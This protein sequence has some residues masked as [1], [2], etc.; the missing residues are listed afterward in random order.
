MLDDWTRVKA[1]FEQAIA[2]DGAERSAFLA[3]A[4]GSDTTLRQRVDLLLVSHDAG[5]SFLEHTAGAVLAIDRRAD[6]LSGQTLGT[7]RLLSRVGTGAMGEV[8]LAHDEKLNRRV[9]VK[10][11]AQHLAADADRLRR[12]RPEAHAV[13]S[14]NHPHIVVVHDVGEMDGRPFI[15]TEFVEGA[16]LRERLAEGPLPIRGAIEIAL[17]ITSALAAAHARGVVHRDIKPENVMIR[18]DGYVKVLDFGLAK[19]ANPE[20]SGDA[21]PGVVT[22]PGHAAGTPSYMSPEQA[23]AEPVDARTDMFSVGAVL[24]EMVTSRMAFPGDSHAVVLAGILEHTPPSPV[25]SNRGVSPELGRIIMKALEK[26]R[27]LRYQT[28]GDMRADL[29]RVRRDSD[30]TPGAAALTHIRAA[31]RWPLVLLP[32]VALLMAAAVWLRVRDQRPNEALPRPDAFPLTTNTGQEQWPAFSPDGKQVTY[33]W[34]GDTGGNPNI[35][36]KL[37]DAGVPLRLTTTP[38]ADLSP[39]WSPDGRYI[40]FLRAATDGFEILSVPSLG[41]PER[42]LAQS[43]AT[44]FVGTRY[45]PWW[46]TKV[47]WSPN[48]NMLAIVDRSSPQSADSIFLLTIDS[49]EKRRLTVP[50]AESYGDGFP[51][52]SPDGRTLAFT[53][54]A[55]LQV[56][57]IFVQTLGPDMSPS[58]EPK[59]VT[60]DGRL[61]AGLDWTADGRELVFSSN[62]AGRHSLWRVAVSGGQPEPLGAGGEDAYAPS[63][64]RQGGRLAY[65]HEQRDTNIWQLAS[66]KESQPTKFI[67]SKREDNAAQFSPD[68]RKIV[69]QSSRSGSFEIWVADRDGSH[70]IQLTFFGGPQAGS[71]RWSPDSRQIAFDSPTKGNTEIHVVSAEGGSPRRLTTGTSDNVRPSWSTDGRWIYF[72]SKRSGEWQVWKI[73]VEGGSAVQVT[74]NGGREAYESPDG[75]TVYYSK[76]GVPGIWRLAVDGGEETQVL[77]AGMQGHWAVYEQGIYVLSTRV[78]PPVIESFGFRAPGRERVTA[79]AREVIPFDGFATTVIASSLDGRSILYVQADQTQSEIMV[80]EKFR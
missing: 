77:A 36:V 60:F 38:D 78:N 56:R 28:A 63:I 65:S 76:L 70:P 73:P 58:G 80:L 17:Q 69:F 10:L 6:D 53:R 47:A 46:P 79:L 14:L 5:K 64:A 22:Q 66:G 4:C 62:R 51:T 72:G 25:Q 41:G 34:D 39:A 11:I 18:P 16:T 61:I 21:T 20:P 23:R 35:F 26:D 59:R 31:Q 30:V 42:K 75:K 44:N 43:I 74:K 45:G 40:A 37:I 7:Y 27:E 29:L 24:Y 48:G 68:G 2:L 33:S 55:G 67:A 49:G 52:F 12:F 13:S 57:D 3:A 71:P 9:A 8:Y 19:L 1:V 54:G 32:V 15:V 50:P